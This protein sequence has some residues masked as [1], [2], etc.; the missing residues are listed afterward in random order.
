M[1]KIIHKNV[2]HSER[3][4]PALLGSTQKHPKTSYKTKPTKP[5]SPNQTYQTKP[6]RPRHL[7]TLK[8]TQKQKGCQRAPKWPKWCGKGSKNT[9]KHP[10]KWPTWSIGHSEPLIIS[11]LIR[12]LLVFRPIRGLKI[13]NGRQG[14][15][16][17]PAGSGKG[18]NPRFSGAP[19]NFR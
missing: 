6:T 4:A 11:F 14:A 10:E 19:V 5:N 3:V 1:K 9:Q 18:S 2:Q 15:P 13:Q 7:K 8:N 12:A 17:W 16:K